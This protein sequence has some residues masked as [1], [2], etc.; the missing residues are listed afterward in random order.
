MFKSS[1]RL[2][3]GENL[4][5]LLLFKCVYGAVAVVALVVQEA[6]QIKPLAVLEVAAQETVKFLLRRV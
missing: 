2:E 3:L 1:H 5:A 4:L 6:M